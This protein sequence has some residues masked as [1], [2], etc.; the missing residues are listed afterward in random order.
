[1]KKVFEDYFSELQAD[2][3][4]ICMEY[5]ENR[6][7]MIYIYCSCEEG[8]ISSDFFYRINGTIKERDKLNDLHSIN[9][10][11][12]SVER[13]DGVLEIIN[14]DIIKIKELC[15]QYGREMPTEM[16]LIYDVKRN[17]LAA[18]YKYDLIYSSDPEKTADNVANEWFEEIKRKNTN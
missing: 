11:N 1:M 12:T 6:A 10:Y 4:S 18:N 2:M 7:E 14:E 8:V 16:K 3:V 13:Q 5:V 9:T 17:S 15:K